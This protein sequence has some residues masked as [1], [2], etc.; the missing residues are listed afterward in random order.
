MIER[1]ELQAGKVLAQHADKMQLY[2][3]DDKV[4][5]KASKKQVKRK[6]AVSSWTILATVVEELASGLFYRLRWDTTG[7]GGE[8]AGELSK[9]VYHWSHLKMREHKGHN[10]VRFMNVTCMSR[11]GRRQ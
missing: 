4:F 7:L 3:V 2:K 9:R 1:Q 8:K 6:Q 10:T 11:F 5:V